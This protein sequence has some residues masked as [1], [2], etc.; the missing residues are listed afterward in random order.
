MEGTAFAIW[1]AL[2]ENKPFTAYREAPEVY[3]YDVRT[4]NDVGTTA[5]KPILHPAPRMGWLTAGGRALK[6]AQMSRFQKDCHAEL[7]L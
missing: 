6:S 2:R 5:T 1:A 4:R 3:S 7:E